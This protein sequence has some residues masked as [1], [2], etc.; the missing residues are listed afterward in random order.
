[1]EEENTLA[2]LG[3]RF[4][5]RVRE[6]LVSPGDEVA[7]INRQGTSVLLV[8]QHVMRGNE[9]SPT[10]SAIRPSRHT[11]FLLY[12]EVDVANKTHII[13][14]LD[15]DSCRKLLFDNPNTVAP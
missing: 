12:Q 10:C 9:G 13:A 2:V 15:V 5:G 1:M 7:E 6:V 8:E 3:R 11:L 4:P 14:D